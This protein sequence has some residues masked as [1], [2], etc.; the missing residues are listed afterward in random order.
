[1]HEHN[2]VHMVIREQH[3]APRK[4]YMTSSKPVSGGSTAPCCMFSMQPCL[5]VCRCRCGVMSC[6][7]ETTQARG[8]FTQH[9][10]CTCWCAWS[11]LQCVGS[12]LN[13][14]FV[15]AQGAIGACYSFSCQCQPVL[16][17]P[18]NSRLNPRGKSSNQEQQIRVLRLSDRCSQSLSELM[19]TAN[20]FSL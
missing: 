9:P 11:I 19:P 6:F 16:F 7:D 10:L 3:N 8:F 20:Q 12:S 14:A 18:L 17:H 13:V 5:D 2:T 15:C 4:A 1:M